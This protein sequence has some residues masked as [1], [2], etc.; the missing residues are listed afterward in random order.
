MIELLVISTVT[1]L[2][3]VA[4]A[5]TTLLA[6]KPGTKLMAF[7]LGLSAGIMALVI[8]ADLLP[9]ALSGGETY[10]ILLGLLVGVV[11]LRTLHYGMDRMAGEA[12]A[13]AR[14]EPTPAHWRQAGWMMGIALALHHIPEGIAIGAGFEA[15]RHIGVLL[16]LSMALHNIPEG[17]G[18]AAPLLLGKL[19][20]RL[21]L[22]FSFLVSLCIPFGAWLGG[23]YFT[24]S[25]Q[26][27]AFGM[28][29]AA[30][31]MSYLVLWELGPSGIRLH[32][33]SAQF[34]MLI[35]LVAMLIL[36]ALPG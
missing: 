15:H 9:A 31:A 30:G 14:T 21:I 10:G 16:A 29:F 4:G 1:G 25:P 20:P 12:L 32:R 3:T 34:G 8:V 33:L 23:I 13:S 28:A 22:L 5:L 36:H 26:A 18:L 2:T 11:M 27:V 7:Y 19:R 17:I 35:S 24:A 6:G